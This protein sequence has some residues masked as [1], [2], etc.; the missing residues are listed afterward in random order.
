MRRSPGED[1]CL[2]LQPPVPQLS[3][4]SP[5]SSRWCLMSPVQGPFLEAPEEPTHPQARP[6]R[7]AKIDICGLEGHR[8]EGSIRSYW[9]A[10]ERHDWSTIL[11][12]AGSK[13]HPP[14][15]PASQTANRFSSFNMSQSTPCQHE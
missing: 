14:S 6:C 11:S 4:R 3:L 8:N 7:R 15:K 2:L 13:Q 10:K 12:S 9:T 1:L 5:L